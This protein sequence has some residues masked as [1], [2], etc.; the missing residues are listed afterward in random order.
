MIVTLSHLGG[1]T[2]ALAGTPVLYASGEEVAMMAIVMG[3]I[4]G[5]A[6]PLIRALARRLE[7]KHAA[8]LPS[9]V[10]EDRLERIE[11]AVEAMSIEVERISEG[12]R[13]VTKLLAEKAPTQLPPRTP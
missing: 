5:V 6:F 11:R 13:F 7:S 3:T 2:S 12:Q 1:L 8:A 4:G 10:V 9:A